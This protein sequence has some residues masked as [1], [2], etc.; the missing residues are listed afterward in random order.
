MS[1]ISKALCLIGI[2]GILLCPEGHTID[3]KKRVLVLHAYHQGFHWTDRIMAGVHS[4]FNDRDDVELFV[5]YMDTKRRSGDFYFGQLKELLRT[6]YEFVKF[7]AIISSDDHALDFL[8]DYRDDLFPDTPIIFSGL[9]AFPADRLSGQKNITGIYESYDVEGTIRLMLELHPET[10]NILAITDETRSGNIFKNLIR[11]VERKFSNRVQ[12]HYF[13]NMSPEDLQFTLASPPENTLV[14]WAIYLRT[15]RGTTL[16]T[17]ESVR[18][19]TEST[20][21]PTYCIWDVVGQGVVG[22]KVTSPN[23]QGEVAGKLALQI[24]NGVPADDIPIVGSPLDNIFDYELVK[25]FNINE[26]LI[27]NNSIFLN[28]PI[29]VYEQYKVYIWFYSSILTLLII[30]I[31][32]LTTTLVLRQR[33]EK[34]EKMAMHDPL[35]GLYNRHYLDAMAA[36]KIA[37]AARY[38]LPMCLLVLDLDKFKLINDTYGHPV[39]DIILKNVSNLLKKHCRSEDIVARIGGEEF[40]I[41]LDRCD[42]E[43]AIEKANL[44]RSSIEASKPNDILVTISIGVTEFI[45]EQQ[46]L[47]GLLEKADKALYQAKDEGRNRVVFK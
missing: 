18:L 45:S 19:V 42:K 39:G 4:V 46:D 2:L 20:S 10:K 9:N 15:P 8:L 5:T 26:E 40:V 11:Q 34:Y 31:L 33:K 3:K 24:L 41:L 17:K 30:T 13:H 21:K 14:L 23:F 12:I 16:T 37:E 27:P 32:F 44:L 28:K 47:N 1:R 25:K 6:R 22:G 36:K 43:K 38:H 7:D 35:T 29:S